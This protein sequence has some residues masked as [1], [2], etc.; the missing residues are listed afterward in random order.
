MWPTN[1]HSSKTLAKY[2]LLLLLL[3]LLLVKRNKTI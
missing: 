3:L 2:L 1:L